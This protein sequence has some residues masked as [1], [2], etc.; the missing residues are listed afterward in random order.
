MW[1][2]GAGFRAEWV[3]GC[4]TFPVSRLRSLSLP[5]SL[6]LLALLVRVVGLG[7]GL[8]NATRW[9]SYHPDESPRQMVGAVA[10]HLLQGDWNPH[11]FNYPSGCIYATTVIYWL[12][13]ALGLTTVAAPSA[14]PWAT[15]RD[16][17]VAGRILS[18][19]CGSATAV[20]V[21]GMAREAGL[22]R[23]AVLAGVLAALCPGL[24]QHSHF[25]TVDVPA[26]FFVAACLW[27]TLHALNNP[28]Q[29]RGWIGAALLA[30]LAAG[31]KYNAGLVVIAPL[32]ALL[33]ARSEAGQNKPARW[34]LPATPALALLA[35][36]VTTPY[37]LLAPSQFWGN[38]QT[39]SGFGYELLV[40]PREGSGEIFQGTGLGWWV[41]LTFNLPFVLTWPLLLAGLWGA[42]VAA[43]DRRQWP[44]LAFALVYFLIIG[45][46]QVRFMRYTF[47]LVPPLLVWLPL[48]LR[49]LPKPDAWAGALLMFAL[50]GTKDALLPLVTPDPR[51]RAAAYMRR[52]G[53]TPTLVGNPWFYTPPF[54][55][56]NDNSPVAGVRIVGFDATKLTP[57]TDTLAVSQYEVREA[58]RLRPDGPEAKFWATAGRG[59]L[60]DSF[61][62]PLPGRNFEPHDYLYTHPRVWVLRL[63]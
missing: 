26:T 18:G 48:G 20:C 49:R 32:V 10:L 2:D 23:G 46:S 19:V 31:A 22:R 35:F 11:F 27:A 16:I 17:I 25:A 37:A 60:F 54:Q 43:K 53:G 36:L 39:Q 6:F 4:H 15:I 8:P 57:G 42:V 38:A 30:G 51:D 13:A 50:A 63:R 34:L 1:Q 47:L 56:R 41:H 28:A 59:V 9:G 21:W 58:L 7:W 5:L 44:L 61:N 3:N 55:P 45:F 52:V 29:T 12:M 24:V 62:T 33:L 14:Y 40:H